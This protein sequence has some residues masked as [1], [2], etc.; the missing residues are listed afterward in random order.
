MT[1]Q[2]QTTTER[3]GTTIIERQATSPTSDRPD[4]RRRSRSR[5]W[6]TSDDGGAARTLSASCP[7]SDADGS[8]SPANPLGLRSTAMAPKSLADRA[9]L[10]AL[11]RLLLPATLP[12]IGC[13][14]AAADYR[15]HNHDFDVGGDW[16]D[17]VDRRDDQVAAIVGDVVGHG[18]R[19]IAVMG[20]LRA[21]SHAM[22]QTLAEPAEVL[23]A[24]DR[25]AVD[26][27]GASFATCAVM[28][29]DGSTTGRL[30]LAGH[31]PPIH[32]RTSGAVEFLTCGHGALL[33]LDGERLTGTFQYAVDDVIVLY[34]DGLVERR[35]ADPMDQALLVGQF[36]SERMNESCERI[37]AAILD[38]FAS[39]ADDDCVVLVLRPKNHR[40]P[41]YILKPLTKPT[42]NFN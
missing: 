40:S 38:E 22:A 19:E 35:G 9:E 34:T 18:V 13:T 31:P 6:S 36:V 32:V 29:L 12:D 42:Q 4:D 10:L 24:L 3:D 28:M 11:Q 26:V 5:G 25:F 23:A 15:S 7:N 39:D 14:E 17:I 27:P 21:V 20:Q 2:V 33:G 30:A 37:A 1:A 16:Y 8:L 41:D